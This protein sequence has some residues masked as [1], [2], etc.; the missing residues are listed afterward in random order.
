MG[1]KDSIKIHSDDKEL[2]GFL[3]QVRALGS[4]VVEAG[5]MRYF[6]SVRTD[7]V[8]KTGR[9]FLAGGGPA[10]ID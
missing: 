3:E 6:V 4:A 10:K 5:G 8:S 7:A 2:L 1:A 9:E